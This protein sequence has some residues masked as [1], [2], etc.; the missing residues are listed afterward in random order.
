MILKIILWLLFL[1]SYC[2]A[3]SLFEDA[4]S[5]NSDGD[6][7]LPYE[8]NGSV[9]GGIFIGENPN[10][11]H[12]DTKDRYGEARF[13]L[14]FEDNSFGSAFSEI[15]IRN[16]FD[17]ENSETKVQLNEAYVNFYTDY[18]DAT[19]GEKVIQW[20]KADGYN[21]TNIVTPM[22]F[23]MFSPDEDDQ[24]RGNFL[25][26][27][28]Y[29]WSDFQIEAIW[30]PVFKFSN[31]PILTD[32]LPNNLKFVGLKF[33]NADLDNSSFALKF[34]YNGA[35]WD[36]SLSYFT[37]FNPNPLLQL[38]NPENS[39][40]IEVLPCKLYQ[41]GTDFSTTFGSFGLRGEVAYRKSFG[42][43]SNSKYIPNDQIEYVI[44]LD[45][46][47]GD[48]SLIVQ[49]LGKYIYDYEK[50]NLTTNSLLINRINSW[51]RILS[52]Q[53]EELS[54]SVTFRP[55]IKL[56]HETLTMEVL[57]QINFSTKEKFLKPKI[58]YDVT[59]HFK[60]IT[61]AQ[62]YK[63]PDKTLM[64]LMEKNTSAFFLQIETNF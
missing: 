15:R 47:F 31:T 29:N 55:S 32:N 10:S 42:E 46:E 60:I 13:K 50:L 23:L 49:Y 19:I 8:I 9:S 61:G 14:K 37:G 4:S 48:F 25:L 51:N 11:S 54:H 59:D 30:L 21:P 58:T 27:S 20:G 28:F 22:D 36:F 3:Q 41:L 63:G 35:S 7:S 52:R 2:F 33:P 16:K 6:V 53:I 18:I 57:G 5:N 40:G 1:I 56:L 38:N 34:Y 39:A 45:R 17:R 26:Q 12:I 62:I 43:I 64:G 24:R 44:G